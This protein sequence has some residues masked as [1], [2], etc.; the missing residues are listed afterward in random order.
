MLFNSLAFAVFLPV[1]FGL[2]WAIQGRVAENRGGLR[3]QNALV[4]V[5]SY[6]FYGW[7]DWRF[8]GLIVASSVV[9]YS[10]GVALGKENAGPRQRKPLLWL[11]IA[12]NLGILGFFK[13]FNFFAASFADVVQAFGMEP[14]LPLLRVILP[15]GISFYTFQTMSYT[16]DVYRRQMEPTRDA[17]AFFAYVAFFPQLVAGPIERAKSL[18]PQFL[19]PRRFDIEEAKDGLRHMLWGL[20]KKVVIADNLAPFVNEIYGSWET[21]SGATLFLGTLFFAIQI[22]C[23]FSGYSDI[24]IGCARLFG[25]RLMRNFAYPYFSRDIGEFWRRWHISLSTWFRDYVYIPLGGSRAGSQVRHL[26]NLILT[27]TVSGFWHGASWNFIVWG[28]LNGMYYL[29]LVLMGRNKQHTGIVAHGRFLPSLREAWQMAV[30]FALVL[31][32]WVFFRA[33][34]MGDAF[35]IIGG[36][37]TRSWTEVGPYLIG[38]PYVGFVLAAEWVQRDKEH[39]LQVGSLPVWARWSL[40]YSLIFL[41]ALFG[42]REEQSFIYFQF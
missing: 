40:Y 11:S 19:V 17:V 15:V 16:L 1:V 4:L 6:V 28:F 3:L 31:F 36:T 32:A 27:F 41:I 9:D 25:F 24:A 8:L 38:L 18:L 12:V 29:P 37:F 23:D 21:A 20:F 39:F 22:Y 2:Y 5:A 34:T 14:N 26:T 30:T 35:G 7:W 42:A 10:V 33:E 13:Y